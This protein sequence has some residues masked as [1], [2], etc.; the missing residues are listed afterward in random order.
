MEVVGRGQIWEMLGE[1]SA[2]GELW[3]G[4][5]EVEWDALFYSRT[6]TNER[7]AR[8]PVAFCSVHPLPLD[9]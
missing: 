9:S 2:Q 1:P 6:P 5:E 7:G 3:E 8:P 4:C